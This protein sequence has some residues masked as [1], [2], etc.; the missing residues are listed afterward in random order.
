MMRWVW[1]KAEMS[2]DASRCQVPWRPARKTTGVQKSLRENSKGPSESSDV[3]SE[4]RTWSGE[5][6][7]TK[8]VDAFAA[9][10]RPMRGPRARS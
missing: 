9:G 8:W 3:L 6:E 2:P 4:V 1:H 5:P 10:R 7:K